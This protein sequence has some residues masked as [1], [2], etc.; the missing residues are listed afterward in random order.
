MLKT[1]AHRAVARVDRVTSVL[2]DTE[3]GWLGGVVNKLRLSCFPPARG[4]GGI[5]RRCRLK[6]GFPWSAGSSPAVRTS[7]IALLA[8]TACQER[9]DKGRK[10]T[11]QGSR[12]HRKLT[13]AREPQRIRK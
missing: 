11:K 6:I 12:G 9:S 5:G 2:G 4:R 8:L 1:L 7:L 3:A 13:D 10:Q